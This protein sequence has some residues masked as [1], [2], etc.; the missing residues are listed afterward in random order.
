MG[1]AAAALDAP[2]AELRAALCVQ[3]RLNVDETGNK[4]GPDKSWTWCLR[5]PF[6]TVYRI[7]ALAWL[8]GAGGDAGDGLRRHPGLRLLLGLPQVHARERRA[9]A[10]LHG[11]PDAGGEVSAEH[12]GPTGSY[13][14]AAGGA[15]ARAVPRPP[16]AGTRAGT[17]GGAWNGKA[18]KLL[19][20]AT[21]PPD[22]RLARNM[23]ERFLKHAESYF[24]FVAEPHVEPTNNLAE[25][26]LRHVVIDR[27]ITQGTRGEAEAWCER[28][29]T[30]RPPAP[31]RAARCSEFL[32]EALTASFTASPP[33]RSCRSDRKTVNGYAQANECDSGRAA[34]TNL[35]HV[36][37]RTRS[38]SRARAG[39]TESRSASVNFPQ[40]CA[41]VQAGQL[42]A[43]G[44]RAPGA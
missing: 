3:P 36:L 40:G 27:R 13:G 17:S 2:Y 30:V 8:E 23:A 9:G 11:A 7:S 16:P 34:G 37:V 10:V 19:R 38:R 18:G 1:K 14:E 32:H 15:A 6:F 33:R 22:T 26:A 31:S 24:R 41:Q 20:V 39:S 4:E 25:Q 42:F 21:H 43:G 44:V 5:A 12:T 29:W 28:I 35:G